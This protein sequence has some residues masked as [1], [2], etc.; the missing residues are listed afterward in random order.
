MDFC[1]Y[2]KKDRFCFN[3][4]DME[5]RLHKTSN[6]TDANFIRNHSLSRILGN[7]YASSILK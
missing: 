4:V 7:L 5:S 1:F 3:C 2:S 6:G